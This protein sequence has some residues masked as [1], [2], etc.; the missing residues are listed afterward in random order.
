MSRLR[1]DDPFPSSRGRV[2]VM[3]ALFLAG[4]LM[5]IIRLFYIQ[6]FKGQDNYR[7]SVENSVRVKIVKAPRGLIL[8]RNGIPI[9]RNRSAWSVAVVYNEL[10]TKKRV[11]ELKNKLLLI[12]DG[13]DLPAFNSKELDKA[14]EKAKI[15]RFETVRI[16]D[17]IGTDV[18]TV[19]MEHLDDLTGIQV[20]EE[21]RREY[22]FG[23]LACHALGYMGE[24]SEEQL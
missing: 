8:D 5:I 10:R 2:G 7:R 15:H 21:S 18:A 20:L 19:L 1:I 6:G 24:V 23:S 3:T 4:A 17:D 16:A 11:E 9:V 12:H 14:F 22:P 13:K